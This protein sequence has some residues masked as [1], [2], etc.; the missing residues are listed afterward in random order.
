MQTLKEIKSAISLLGKQE[1]EQLLSDLQIGHYKE[2]SY[3][4]ELLL[5]IDQDRP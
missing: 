4:S 3:L 5:K 2:G 1:R